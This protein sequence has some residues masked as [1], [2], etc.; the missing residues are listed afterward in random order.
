VC[1]GGAGIRVA[2]RPRSKAVPCRALQPHATSEKQMGRAGS[3][4]GAAR[5]SNVVIA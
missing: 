1:K 3:S 4:I 5:T 2:A